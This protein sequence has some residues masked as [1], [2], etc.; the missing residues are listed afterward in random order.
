M[1]TVI[2][3]IAVLSA[4]VMLFAVQ[5]CK[6]K[7]DPFDDNIFLVSSERAVTYTETNILT[8][9]NVAKTMYPGVSQIISDVNSGIVVYSIT[10]NTT[11]KGEDLIASGIIAVPSVPGSY[12]VLAYQNGTNT[13][14]AN[15]PSV[16]PELTLYQ[17][18]EMAASTGYIVVMT[19][20]LGF[21]ASEEIAHPYLHKESTV[22]T[23]VDMFRALQEF[24]EDIAKDV[25]V[26]NE[27]YLMGYSQGGW[28]TLALLEAMENDYAADFNTAGC[29]CGAGPYDISYFN[30]WLLGLTEYS[31]P[32]YIGYISNAYKTHG[33]FT[34]PLSDIFKDPFAARIPTLYDG[35]R[36]TEQIN[37]QLTEVVGDLFKPEYISGFAASPSFQ[38]VR[39]AMTA[40]S[41]QGWNC[42]IPLLLLHGTADTYVPEVLSQRMYDAMI[43]AGTATSSCAYVKMDGI[44]HGSGIVPAGL[45]G[46][47]FFKSLRQQT[48]G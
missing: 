19:D 21:G 41:V 45:A 9:L 14:Y 1:R 34:N 42:H 48:G 24:D 11:F 26:D 22:Q 30:S 23:V 25:T 29:S 4:A 8:L 12:P 36:S 17:L 39:T 44:D 27:Y 37:D 46:L 38:S 2:K 28:A 32:S 15:A 3:S 7:T 13:L 18:I 6:E 40:N 33:L 5:S 16:N 43:G 10:Y 31:M 35:L 20:Y 47:A